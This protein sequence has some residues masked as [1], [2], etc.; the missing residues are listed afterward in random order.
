MVHAG[1]AAGKFTGDCWADDVKANPP[2]ST[3]VKRRVLGFIILNVI[4]I[5]F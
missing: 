2:A 4:E 1:L 3:N 5:D